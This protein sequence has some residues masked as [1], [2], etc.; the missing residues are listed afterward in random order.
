MAQGEG[1]LPGSLLLGE[2]LS[3]NYLGCRR[4]RRMPGRAKGRQ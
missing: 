4:G 1:Q 3:F 2:V